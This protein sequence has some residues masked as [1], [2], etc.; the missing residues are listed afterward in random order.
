MEA[1][2]TNASVEEAMKQRSHA[3]VGL[4]LL[5]EYLPNLPRQYARLFLL[6]CIQPD[7][8]PATYLKGSIRSQW[9]HGHNYENAAPFLFRLIRRLEGK[10]RFSAWDYYSLGKV[11][12]YTL[13]AF[14]Y[15]H[16]SH[17]EKSLSEH[18]VYEDQLQRYFLAQLQ[19]YRPET[20]VTLQSTVSLLRQ[21]HDEYLQR[22]GCIQNDTHCALKA[23]CFVTQRLTYNVTHTQKEPFFARASHLLK[24]SIRPLFHSTTFIS[25]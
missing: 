3:A 19:Q 15:A 24:D 13:D 20:C 16:N 8:N 5:N 12:H 21:S 25:F 6:G 4:F 17:F 11:V 1:D 18:C 2:Q 23:V 10:R 22:P 9:L 7:R 14:T